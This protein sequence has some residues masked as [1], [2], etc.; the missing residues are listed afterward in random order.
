MISSELSFMPEILSNSIYKYKY[1]H[2]NISNEFSNWMKYKHYPIVSWIQESRPYGILSQNFRTSY[3]KW[4]IPIR[5]TF[6]PTTLNFEYHIFSEPYMLSSQK[7]ITHTLYSREDFTIIDIRQAGKYVS[8]L[9]IFIC[10]HIYIHYISRN[11]FLALFLSIFEYL[12]L[13]S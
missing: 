10:I 3:G 5:L 8:K 2:I 11:Y 9:F 12:L 4:W 13:F 1:I 7:P 6:I